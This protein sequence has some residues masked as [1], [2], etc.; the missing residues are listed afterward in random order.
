MEIFCD[1]NWTEDVQ[2]E[3][4]CWSTLPADWG[5]C[6]PAL[7]SWLFSAAGRMS[8][9]YLSS[10]PMWVCVAVVATHCIYLFPVYDRCLL[11]LRCNTT[12]HYVEVSTRSIFNFIN[13]IVIVIHL[14][15]IL[16]LYLPLVAL[17]QYW[18]PAIKKIKI[19]VVIFSH[20]LFE[21]HI[22]YLNKLL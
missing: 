21:S 1:H 11:V 16:A 5:F 7:T 22:S 9:F 17:C 3:L 12:N 4:Y 19:F 13:I 20:P 8:D 14:L 6:H 18:H 15:E 10:P 2:K